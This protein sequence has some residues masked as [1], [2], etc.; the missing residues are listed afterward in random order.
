MEGSGTT[1]ILTTCL[2]DVGTVLN[3]FLDFAVENK[4]LAFFIGCGVFLTAGAV[5]FAVKR[6]ATK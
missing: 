2:A 6:K 1:N 3:S 5:F 4:L